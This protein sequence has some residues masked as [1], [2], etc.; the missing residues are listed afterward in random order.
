M[1]EAFIQETESAQVDSGLSRLRQKI[2]NQV[3]KEGLNPSEYLQGSGFQFLASADFRLSG[4]VF[5]RAIHFYPHNLPHYLKER[6]VEDIRAALFSD[7]NS[8]LPVLSERRRSTLIYDLSG[9]K[10]EKRKEAIAMVEKRLFASFLVVT[11]H[12][13]DSVFVRLP[14]VSREKVDPESFRFLIFPD[15]VWDALPQLPFP[16]DGVITVPD[17]SKNWKF[18][19]SSLSLRIPD[20]ESGIG[21]ALSQ[22]K[23][24]IWVHGVRLPAEEDF[25]RLQVKQ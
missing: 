4:S 12:R 1:V 20:Y 15:K 17:I 10:E 14:L 6:Q 23:K 2:I 16:R 19:M 8:I 21:L 7:D 18:R 25:A 11:E 24:P 5:G 9:L 13:A 3:L 22:L